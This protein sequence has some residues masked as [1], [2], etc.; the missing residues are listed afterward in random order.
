MRNRYK[1]E[2]KLS[3][4]L[5]QFK[6]KKHVKRGIDEAQLKESWNNTMGKYICKYTDK[7]YYSNSVLYVKLSSAPLRQELSANAQKIKEK[8]NNDIGRDIIARVV[9]R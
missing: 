2:K 7:I 4:I 6:G 3:Q 9:L 1:P 5:D 8:L